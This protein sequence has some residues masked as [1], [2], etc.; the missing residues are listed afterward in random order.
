MNIVEKF[1]VY[2]CTLWLFFG[3]GGGVLEI[4]IGCL[5]IN[6]TLAINLAEAISFL[7]IC[8]YHIFIFSQ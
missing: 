8:F 1:S 2:L 3:V 6:D 7:K 5:K 4:I